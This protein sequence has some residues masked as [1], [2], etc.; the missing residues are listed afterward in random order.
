MR[1]NAADARRYN[2]L[3]N[4]HYFAEAFPLNVRYFCIVGRV[5][6][7]YQNKR[8]FIFWTAQDFLQ[9]LHRARRVRQC[10]EAHVVQSS[11]QHPDGDADRFL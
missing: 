11:E 9:E 10:G 8:D 3:D 6:D 5:P 4:F 1:A 7:R 2:R